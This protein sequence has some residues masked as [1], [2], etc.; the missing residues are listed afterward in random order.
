MVRVECW[1]GWSK[2]QGG[3]KTRLEYSL[4]RGIGRVGVLVN[5]AGE[6]RL[7]WKVGWGRVLG[8]EDG[9]G[10]EDRGRV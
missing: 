4:G 1:K 3:G 2:G 7:G 5:I 9:S 6:D 10:S 8:S